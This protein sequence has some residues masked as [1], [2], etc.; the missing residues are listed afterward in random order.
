ML[1]QKAS[2]RTVPTSRPSG[3]RSQPSSSRVRIVVAPGRLRQNAAKSCSPR[4]A[5][6][7]PAMAASSRG[8]DATSTWLRR[9][10]S[11]ASARSAIR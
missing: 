6:E 9:S 7:A 4:S 10:G 5:S 2:A 3:C 1:W 11:T 8:C